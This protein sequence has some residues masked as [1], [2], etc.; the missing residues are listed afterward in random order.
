LQ[1]IKAGTYETERLPT[2]ADKWLTEYAD[3]HDMA[4][5][6]F[7]F[8]GAR[9][10]GVKPAALVV[11]FDVRVAGLVLEEAWA[12]ACNYGDVS[13]HRPEISARLPDGKIELSITN[14]QVPGKRL[15]E[16]AHLF[17][18]R[19]TRGAQV[20]GGRLSN[21][22]GLADALQ[23]AKA[24]GGTVSLR[25]H[26]IAEVW[27]TTFTVCLPASQSAASDS[28]AIG[29]APEPPKDAP[30]TPP[31]KRP[32]APA[33]LYLHNGG[34]A[35][36]IAPISERRPFP[37]GLTVVACDD[38]RVQR[39]VLKRLILPK[40]HAAE[41]S[42]VLGENE[43]EIRSVVPQ[44]LALEADIVILDQNLFHGGIVGTQLAGELRAA[45]FGG[46]I[47]LRTG[48][49]GEQFLKHR[50]RGLLDLVV[51]KRQMNAEVVEEIK[52]AYGRGGSVVPEAAAA[53]A[54]PLLLPAS[55][56]P[57][58]KDGHTSGR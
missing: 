41:A 43:D 18:E 27:Y 3:S 31:P 7:A 33:A 22:F 11:H 14:R 12:N 51:D 1:S 29:V 16:N 15:P 21:G 56:L 52:K 6:S 28:V 49:S 32:T 8:W 9:G 45:G 34:A 37:E 19:G 50:E 10:G 24:A 38:E 17:F 42:L 2:P 58:K 47:V 39:K 5:S 26:V 30:V 4:K 54:S 40:L 23:S 35:A 13:K 48:S 44:T 25:E 20:V 46:F 53:A 36:K 55:T 57:A